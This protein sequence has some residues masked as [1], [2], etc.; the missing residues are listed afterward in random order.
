MTFD[1]TDV[2]LNVLSRYHYLLACGYLSKIF[3]I[4]SVH[5]VAILWAIGRRFAYWRISFHCRLLPLH[6]GG[7]SLLTRVHQDVRRSWN[8]LRWATLVVLVKFS[9]VRFIFLTLAVIGRIITPAISVMTVSLRQIVRVSTSIIAFIHV[10]TLLQTD[11]E[12]LLI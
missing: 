1:L 3:C 4:F 10:D 11:A 6:T 12:G 8:W 2:E 7:R 9:Q 5:F